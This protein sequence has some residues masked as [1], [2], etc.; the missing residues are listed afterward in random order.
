MTEQLIQLHKNRM[1]QSTNYSEWKDAAQTLDSLEYK[2]IWK[3]TIASDIYNYEMLSDRL[4]TLRKHREQG[5]LK[6]LARALREGL[7]HDL[8]NM[9]DIRL[10]Q[11]S[12]FGTKQLIEDYVTEVCDCLDVLSDSSSEVMSASKKLDFFKDVLL[13]FGRPALLLSGGASLGVFHV[14]VVKALWEHNLLPQVVTGSSAG[15]IIAAALGTHTDSEIPS[16]FDPNVHNIKAW[17]W[18]GLL[19]GLKGKGFMDQKQLQDYIRSYVGEYTF[20][21][22]YE[23]TGRSINITVSPV[24]HHQK[25]RLLC[26]YTS[27]YLLTWSAAL[28]SCA[29]P[30]IFPPVKLLKR[31]QFG[32][33]VPYMPRLRWVDGSVVSDLPVERLMHLYDVNYTV[34]SQTNPHVVP[35]LDRQIAQASNKLLNL[36]MSIFKAEAKFHGKAV[37]DYI[38]KNTG[39]QVLRQ[40][41]GHAYSMMSQNY[42]GDVTIAPKYKLAHYLKI[43]SNPDQKMIKELML[44]GERATWPKLAMIRTHA[45]ISKNLEDNIARL[46]RNVRSHSGKLK[47]IS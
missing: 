12:Y 47:L 34:V 26:G 8:G 20:Q 11:Q 9:G 42:Y 30:G 17:R 41:S 24:Q 19:S 36:P 6:L 2:D 18:M 22:A 35:F 45:K 29:V 33:N 4:F 40:V 3:R 5:E 31:D 27:P 37:F 39:S 21:E 16:L 25:E 7:H 32:K 15:S 23:R 46:K 1:N 14:G 28:A 38:R 13:S 44:E 43:L 10:Y